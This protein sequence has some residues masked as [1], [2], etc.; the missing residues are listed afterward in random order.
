MATTQLKTYRAHS[1]AE[2]LNEVK[3]DLGP[4]AVILH[5]RTY[6][7][8]A[9][10]GV[11]GKQVVEITA[12]SEPAPRNRIGGERQAQPAQPPSKSIG[13]FKSTAFSQIEVKESP[14]IARISPSAGAA[15]PIV[16]RS[17]AT[18]VAPA[19]VNVA[20]FES[21][22]SELA[23]IR[24]LVGQVLHTTRTQSADLT[25][26]NLS[27][28][29]VTLHANLV[30]A[31]V[32]VGLAD[33][34]IAQVRDDLSPAERDDAQTARSALLAALARAIPVA[35][36]AA[37]AQRQPDGRPFILAIVG[38][39]GAGKT[40]T[41]AK[42]AAHIRLRQGR[43]VAIITTDA[44]RMAAIDQVRAYAQILSVPVKVALTPHELSAHLA[45]C[46]DV[47]AV[48]IDT[49]GRS[50]HDA[51]R[52]GE[53]RALLDAAQPHETHLAL[54]STL[55][56]NVLL[57]TLERFAALNPTRAILTKL[58]EA[59]SIGPLFAAV[60]PMLPKLSYI[61]TGQEVPDDFAPANANRLARWVLDGL[62][63]SVRGPS[64]ERENAST[65]A[66]RSAAYA[67]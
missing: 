11:G 62:P 32:P 26:A 28:P 58:D 36:P 34:L 67:I 53:L 49:P 20:A 3:A 18:P 17:L 37:P 57:R 41:L 31:E 52:L 6:K 12:S 13:E 65:P 63:T 35:A 54:P 22:Q 50:H 40:T 10:M 21:L 24:R 66:A 2:A 45:S 29:L 43:K 30:D 16:E 55:A 51:T 39:T 5:T 23:G 48:L 7:S 59:L 1:M 8:G 46:A 14:V 19:P 38:P 15:R 47:D 25:S 42:L 33:R 64:D 61:T 44:Y 27:E 60:S 56:P 4:S 9:V